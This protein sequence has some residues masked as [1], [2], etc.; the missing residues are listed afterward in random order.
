MCPS[1]RTSLPRQLLIVDTGIIRELVTFRA[2]DEFRF[3]RLHPK[4]RFIRDR[5]AYQKC[6]RFIAEFKRKVT[7]ASVCAELNYWIR[8]TEDHGQIKLWNLVYEEF[9]N[10]G[11][12]EEA[13]KLT[14]MR[15]SLSLVSRL[16]PVDLSLI[17]IA[18]RHVESSPHVLTI[19][20]REL[21]DECEKRKIKVEF[22]SQV[23]S[24]VSN[25]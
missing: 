21:Y 13:I 3:M 14:D 12:E 20:T 9:R 2:V 18:G 8:G 10:L 23:I 17:E 1:A 19:D 24:N 6:S 5:A 7:S 22:L 4:L 15:A 11:L 25:P 16:G